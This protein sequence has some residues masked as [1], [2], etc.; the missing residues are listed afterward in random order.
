VVV[1]ASNAEHWARNSLNFN[2]QKTLD[3]LVSQAMLK[4]GIRLDE[5]QLTN[6]KEVEKLLLEQRLPEQPTPIIFEVSGVIRNTL[7]QKDEDYETIK[8]YGLLLMQAFSGW[9]Q[10]IQITELSSIEDQAILE[11]KKRKLLDYELDFFVLTQYRS[12]YFDKATQLAKLAGIQSNTNEKENLYLQ[13]IRIAER[14]RELTPEWHDDFS[15]LQADAHVGLAELDS[16]K[17]KQHYAF[18]IELLKN[19]KGTANLERI[20]SKIGKCY[21]ALADLTEDETTQIRAGIEGITAYRKSAIHE[22][23]VLKLLPYDE[24]QKKIQYFIRSL[25]RL[26]SGFMKIGRYLV[27]EHNIPTDVFESAAKLGIRQQTLPKSRYFET[28]SEIAYNVL[29]LADKHLKHAYRLLWKYPF[30]CDD[31][32][33]KLGHTLLTQAQIAVAQGKIKGLS[34]G[35]RKKRLT[36]AA[37]LLSK[38]PKT[39]VF[40]ESILLRIFLVSKVTFLLD[41]ASCAGATF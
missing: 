34:G 15:E 9:A 4:Y 28:R 32:E 22:F 1:N 39:L 17:A 27:R 20:Y 36:Y 25:Q 8:P 24:K 29:N 13:I 38:V 35:W 21:Y 16:K 18:A 33:N 30:G 14:K 26:A 37:R 5:T 2:K 11:E 12:Q 41:L 19:H 23:K 7:K 31:L 6:I 40:R 10:Q 3:E